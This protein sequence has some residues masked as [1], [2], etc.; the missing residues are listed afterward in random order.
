[1]IRVSATCLSD[2]GWPRVVGALASCCQTERAAAEF[3]AGSPF[4]DGAAAV[5]AMY[6]AT[7]ELRRLQDADAPLPL[8]G[9]TDIRPIVARCR[10]GGTAS[11]DE[12]IAVAACAEGLGRAF[13][14]VRTHAATAP[15][16]CALASELTDLGRLGQQLASTFDASGH[17]RDDASPELRD[18]RRRL[19]SIRQ[20]IKERLDRYIQRADLAGMIQDD[21]YTEREE[22]YVVPIVASFQSQV[23]GIIHGAS[24]TGQ[25]VFIE[26]EEFIP[27]N[28]ELKLMLSRVESETLRVLI[29]RSR[30]VAEHADAL[31]AGLEAATALDAVAARALFA[32]RHGGAIVE[33]AEDGAMRL[34]EARNPLLLLDGVNVVPNDIVLDGDCAFVLVTGPNTGGK[35]VTLITVGLMILM[36]HAAIPLCADSTSRVVLFDTL[37]AIIGDAQDIHRDLSTFSGHLE[38]LSRLLDQADRRT[39][40]LLDELIVGTEPALGAALAIAV[41]EALA[42]LGAR[43]FV[44]TH[45]E[46]LKLLAYEDARFANA[47]VGLDRDSFAPTYR[48]AVG[49]PG[50][51]S[52]FEIAAR[53]GFDAQ[54]LARARAISVGDAGLAEAIERLGAARARAEADAKDARAAAES[55]RA[56]AA[57]LAKQRELLAREAAREVAELR[58]EARAEIRAARELIRDQVRDVQDERDPAALEKKRKTVAEVEARLAEAEARDSEAAADSEAPPSPP[59][60]AKPAAS[61]PRDG[62]DF[63]TP[64][65]PGARVWVRSLKR[66]GDVVETRGRDVLVAIGALK[67]TVEASRLGRVAGEAV[68]AA[69]AAKKPKSRGKSDDGGA[70]DASQLVPPPRTDAITLDLRGQRRD[71]VADQVERFL[72][73]AW[74]ADDEVV[75]IIHGHGTGALRDEVRAVVARTACVRGSRP[76]R[77]N[78]GGD[79]VTLA[80]LSLD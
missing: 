79:G 10:R 80:W 46:R 70:I 49:E 73:H 67:M 39:L 52:P 9:V 19:A 60:G 74:Q 38:A 36:A 50:A 75:W 4:L 37:F 18:A 7:A 24:Q 58:K 65:G 31:A 41:L 20:N 14:Y 25:T 59:R 1:M 66:V 76:G 15:R 16:L 47:S 21:Y 68:E 40:V 72:D 33:V 28:N 22:R 64:P 61:G 13:R 27:A 45:Y 62:G 11:V 43:G 3:S 57:R 6:E 2:L 77:A 5:R 71:E 63:D 12:L 29:E 53:L 44:T 17:I 78:E 26:P 23:S 42:S 55:A 56:E 34:V 51:S 48:L 32:A 30:W 54:I 35:T 8:A 69:P